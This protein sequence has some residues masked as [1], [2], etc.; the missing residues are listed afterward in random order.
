MRYLVVS[1]IICLAMGAIGCET[2]A[3]PVPDGTRAE[4]KTSVEQSATGP[5]YEDDDFR[6]T[7]EAPTTCQM[8]GPMAP[9]EPLRRISVPVALVGR[10]GREVPVG[11]MLFTLEDKEGHQFRPTLAGCGPSLTPTAVTSGKS[12]Q[13]EIAF[14]VPQGAGA[15]E[16]IFEPFLIG[17]K[18]VTARISVPASERGR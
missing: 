8:N 3:E 6:L 15:L 5:S 16:L 7:V 12:L 18:K 2:K 4:W 1:T 14:D 10:S 11:P 9:S 17:R 13:G